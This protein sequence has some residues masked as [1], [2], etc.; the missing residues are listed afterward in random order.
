MISLALTQVE[1]WKAARGLFVDS[2]GTAL[3]TGFAMV[4]LFIAVMLLFWVFYTYRRTEHRLN[5]KVA[6]LSVTSIKQEQE[7][8]KLTETN[9]KLRQ[10]NTELYRKQVEVLENVKEANPSVEPSRN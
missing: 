2:S 6:D 9:E 8:T 3:L 10:E 1:G 4:A 5:L 7:I